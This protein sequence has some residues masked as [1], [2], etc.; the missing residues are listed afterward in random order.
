MF[1]TTRAELQDHMESPPGVC[2]EPIE[3]VDS[4]FERHWS[5]VAGAGGSTYRRD[6]SAAGERRAGARPERGPEHCDGVC[7]GSEI[8]S[9]PLPRQWKMVM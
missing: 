9:K 8:S 5:S 7:V 3:L 6:E 4:L 2:H 1:C